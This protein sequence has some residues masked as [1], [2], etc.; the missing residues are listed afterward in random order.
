MTVRHS[1]LRAVCLGDIG[2]PLP[3]TRL[4]AAF[5]ALPWYT[6]YCSGTCGNNMDS[7]TK[8]EEDAVADFGR[9]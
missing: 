1:Q 5:R 8:N 9:D 7:I 4:V 2:R 6:I 3:V